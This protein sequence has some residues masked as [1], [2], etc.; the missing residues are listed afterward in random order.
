METKQT[1]NM[2][3]IKYIIKDLYRENDNEYYLSEETTGLEDIWY[4]MWPKSEVKIQGKYNPKIFGD[5][6]E[7]KRYL[8]E[9]KRIS[10]T[11]YN[12]KKHLH[13]VYGLSKPQWDIYEYN[14]TYG[15]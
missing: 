5:M 12:N 1:N 14:E 15:K 7:A 11:D 4:K 13:K 3:K 2:E 10:N 8:K 9:I 6:I